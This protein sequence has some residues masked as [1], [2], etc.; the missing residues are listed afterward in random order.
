MKW[1]CASHAQETGSKDRLQSKAFY[2][3]L[4]V[5]VSVLQCWQRPQ[6]AARSSKAGWFKVSG[7]NGL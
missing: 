1:A 5:R 2:Y 7:K 4:H 6:Y 3:S